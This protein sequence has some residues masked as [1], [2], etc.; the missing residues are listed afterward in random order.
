MCDGGSIVMKRIM[1]MA[2]LI[3]ALAVPVQAGYD[4]GWEAYLRGDYA[5]ALHEWH[6]LADQ[7][8]CDWSC[9]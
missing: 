8:I 2:V 9:V 4:E 1:G 3:V 7:G 5:T 6:P